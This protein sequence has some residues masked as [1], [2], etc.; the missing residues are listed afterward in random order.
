MEFELLQSSDNISNAD[1]MSKWSN[2]KSYWP[3][4]TIYAKSRSGEL[5]WKENTHTIQKQPQCINILASFQIVMR[6]I[7]SSVYT[8]P[9]NLC[10]HLLCKL[11]GNPKVLLR[12]KVVESSVTFTLV[13]ITKQNSKIIRDKW[14]I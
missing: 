5:L 13:S 9:P 1:N 12:S 3:C 2:T 8:W 6:G 4:S 10:V 14:T 7:G 11:I